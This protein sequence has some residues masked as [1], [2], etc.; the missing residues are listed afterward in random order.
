MT[1]HYNKNLKIFA[2]E[3]RNNSTPEEIKLWG[4]LRR[5]LFMGYD[6]HRQKPVGNYIADFYCYKLRLVIEVDGSWHFVDDETMRRDLQKQ[7]YLKSIGLQ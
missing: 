6:F 4:H 3:L 1:V 7:E 5:G 2:R